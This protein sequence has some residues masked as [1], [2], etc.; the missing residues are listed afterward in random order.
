VKFIAS[1]L[2]AHINVVGECNY[3]QAFQGAHI[4]V[5]GEC[6]YKQA[7]IYPSKPSKQGHPQKNF[8]ER[9]ATVKKTKKDRKLALLS[10]Y[11][12]TSIPCKKIQGGARP[13]ALHCRRPCFQAN[14]SSTD[15]YSHLFNLAFLH[16]QAI[17]H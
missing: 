8:K 15:E 3:K 7:F 1:K 2:F 13:L 9:G 11:S 12:S 16:W 5:V 10:L 17:F 6:N 4:N 14:F